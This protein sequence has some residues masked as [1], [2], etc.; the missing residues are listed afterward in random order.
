MSRIFYPGFE[1]ITYEKFDELEATQ[2]V[3]KHSF[4]AYC[5]CIIPGDAFWDEGD[6]PLLHD[7][8][9]FT[10]RSEMMLHWLVRD[11]EDIYDPIIH[12]RSSPL[13]IG[14]DGETSVGYGE[15]P[16]ESMRHAIELWQDALIEKS[17]QKIEA[18]FNEPNPWNR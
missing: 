16:V 6:D 17:R 12:V 1:P 18:V 4:E 15:T 2:G 9:S 8:E 10:H 3:P 11:N 7:F 5:T 13:S 14:S